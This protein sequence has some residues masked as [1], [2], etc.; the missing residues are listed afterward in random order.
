MKK[1]DASKYD[2]PSVSLDLVIMSYDVDHKTIKILTEQRDREPYAGKIGLPG[3]IVKTNETFADAIQRIFSE[4]LSDVISFRDVTM[5]QLYTFDALDRDPRL[6]MIGVSY[7]V[8]VPLDKVNQHTN[9]KAFYFMDARRE[10]DGKISVIGNDSKKFSNDEFAFDHAE[11][12]SCAWYRV[13]NKIEYT[14]TAFYMLP[15]KMSLGMI[16]NEYE[17]LLGKR[18]DKPNFRKF[19]KKFV[20]ETDEYEDNVNHRPGKLF[21]LSPKWSNVFWR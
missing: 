9:N 14:N 4:K 7:L 13:A 6:R 20:E 12:I 2:K 1:Y 11:I 16:Q 5:E 19:I 17:A 15:E 21:K 10:P 8:F 3:T 18:L